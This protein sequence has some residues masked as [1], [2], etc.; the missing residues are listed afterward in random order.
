MHSF[1][2]R[3]VPFG[4]W[5]RPSRAGAQVGQLFM[6]LALLREQTGILIEEAEKRLAAQF[7]V[8]HVI[9]IDASEWPALTRAILA[10]FQS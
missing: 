6:Q 4:G 10:L 1:P 3:R 7:S 2:P 9:D 8:A 5:R